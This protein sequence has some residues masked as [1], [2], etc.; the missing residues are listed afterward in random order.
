MPNQPPY[1]GMYR[2][3]AAAPPPL[4]DHI[5]IPAAPG[6]PRG[7]QASPAHPAMRGE[8]WCRN[9]HKTG[10]QN[11]LAEPAGPGV[12]QIEQRHLPLGGMRT[13]LESTSS[14]RWKLNFQL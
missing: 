13:T 2:S 12:M 5:P 1:S 10:L 8:S 11:L 4:R 6:T 3:S 7:V 9:Y 14:F